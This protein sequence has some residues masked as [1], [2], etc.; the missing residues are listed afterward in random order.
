MSKSV[1]IKSCASREEAEFLS[2][3][4]EENGIKVMVSTDDCAGLLLPTS[5]GVQ[6]LVLE[7][8]AARARQILADAEE[9]G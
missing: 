8:H 6:L 9:Q 7:E 3:M 4:L 1:S 5:G 2:S